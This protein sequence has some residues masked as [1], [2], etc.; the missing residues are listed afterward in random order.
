MLR[1]HQYSQKDQ[2]HHV[3]HT[4]ENSKTFNHYLCGLELVIN[5][6]TM[7]RHFKKFLKLKCG[8]LKYLQKSDQK[9][10]FFRVR[11]ARIVVQ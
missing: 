3:K 11:N 9:M 8:K 5:V 2:F 1:K 7:N 4:K 10:Y 6:T